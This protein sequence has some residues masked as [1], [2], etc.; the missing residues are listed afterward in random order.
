MRKRIRRGKSYPIRG[1]CMTCTETYTS[2]ARAGLANAL[3][4]RCLTRRGLIWACFGWFAVAV[5]PDPIGSSLPTG[6][7]RRTASITSSRLPRSAASVSALSWSQLSH[8]RQPACALPVT[9]PSATKADLSEWI[10]LERVADVVGQLLALI[11]Q[12][13]KR[14]LGRRIGD[15]QPLI[16]PSTF[17]SVTAACSAPVD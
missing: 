6:A 9:N 3:V 16:S 12:G 5:G 1:A 15:C 4:A 10:R 8:E 17:P 11:M 13:L 14:G 7:G 2:G